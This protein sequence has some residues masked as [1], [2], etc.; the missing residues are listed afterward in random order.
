MTE[1]NNQEDRIDESV[2]TDSPDAQG[3][4]R[5]AESEQDIDGGG[6]DGPA[7]ATEYD[8]SDDDPEVDDEHD[9]PSSSDDADDASD[10]DEL[11]D[12]IFVSPDDED[13]EV[14][15][16][17]E[18]DDDASDDGDGASATDDEA[19]GDAE[20]D[21]GQQERIAELSD[22]VEQQQ[23]RIDE[24]E[25]NL[26]E[27]RQERDEFNE[28]MLRKAADL[29]NFRRRA[30][31]EK[32]ELKKYGIDDF[33]LELIPALDNMERALEH[34]R[35]DASNDSMVD[36]VEMVYRQINTA[37]EKHGV[38]GFDAVG[39]RFDPEQHEAIQQ[40]E[41]SEHD[42]GTVLEEFQKGYFLHDR[43][44]RPALVSVAK[45][46]E[47]DDEGGAVA[48]VDA[49]QQGDDGVESVDEGDEEAGA[50]SESD[51]DDQGDEATAETEQDD[52]TEQDG[53]TE[54]AK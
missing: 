6:D 20:E 29:D 30:K 19:D 26:E 14:V 25:Q 10:D 49:T 34:A 36:G 23:Q 42:T 28:K 16:D 15:D 13:V 47:S 3:E 44:L 38:Q 54:S 11:H 33:V 52:S 5:D 40:V 43:L 45:Y 22:K 31:R 9:E 12:D 50:P 39:E 46:V 35:S 2:D 53:D 51:D 24:L 17:L 21:D 27:A 18:S 1:R 41:T 8:A 4:Q 7:D 32:E 37:L 48:D